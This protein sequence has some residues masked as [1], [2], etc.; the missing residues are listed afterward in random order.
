MQAIVFAFSSPALLHVLFFT[1]R[2][3]L[4]GTKPRSFHDSSL[5]SQILP[6]MLPNLIEGN[7]HGIVAIQTLY[8]CPIQHRTTYCLW[9]QDLAFEQNIPDE[10]GLVTSKK[11]VMVGCQ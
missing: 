10:T 3:S 6:D 5:L 9:E 7:P 2:C 11:V 8:Q 4:D 1:L